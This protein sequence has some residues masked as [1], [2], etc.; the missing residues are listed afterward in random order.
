MKKGEI[1]K[2]GDKIIL[3][4]LFLSILILPDVVAVGDIAYIMKNPRMV[5]QNIVNSF[6]DLGFTID[7]IKDSNVKKIDFSK[8]KIIFLGDERIRTTA[9][10][11]DITKSKTIVMNYYYGEEFGLTDK[12]GVAN[13][14]ASSPLKVVK[15]NKVIPVYTTAKVN[16]RA[17]PYYYL[18]KNNKIQG[19]KQIASPYTGDGEDG[20][21][22]VISYANEGDVLGNGK[23]VKE[24]MCFFGIAK[25]NY[26]TS[27]AKK[28]F[29]DCIDF[30][31]V[32]CYQNTECN[33]KNDY[34]EDVCVNPGT[35]T[36]NC[37]HNPIICL[38]ESDCGEDKY[39][40]EN[41]CTANNVTKNFINYT[42]NLPGT[43][44][45]S[46]SNSTTMKL[47]E[48]C[49]FGCENGKCLIGKHDIALENLQ[50][51][52]NDSVIGDNILVKNVSY[53][54][55]IDVF[56]KGN[57]MENVSFDGKILQNS[58]VKKTFKHAEIKNLEA[59]GSKLGKYSS[60]L[61]DLT[62]G[63]Y[64]VSVKGIVS[65]DENLD[66]NVVQK[67]I[68]LIEC[69][70]K[71]DCKENQ[72]CIAPGTIQSKCENVI[73]NCA[74]NSDCGMDRV[75]ANYCLNGNV[76]HDLTF[77]NCL[78]PGTSQSYCSSQ[79]TTS[80]VQN[81]IY[82][83][84]NGA[85]NPTPNIKCNKN[86]DCNDN[87]PL[88]IDE[89]LNAG[90]IASKCRNTEIN[91]ASNNNCGITGFLGTE[92]CSVNDVFKNYQTAN[93]L[94]AGTLQSYCM[95]QVEQKLVND[96][97]YTCSDGICI[98]CN[99]DLECDDKNLGTQDKCLNPGTSRSYCENKPIQQD[100]GC[101]DTETKND[102]FE[103]GT[104]YDN[105]NGQRIEHPDVCDTTPDKKLWQTSCNASNRCEHW[106]YYCPEGWSCQEGAC[107]PKKNETIPTCEDTDTK[108]DVFKWGTCYDYYGLGKF[109]NQIVEHPDVCDDDPLIAEKKVWQTSCNASNMCDHWY[110]YCPEGWHCSGGVCV[111]K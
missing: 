31:A 44:A 47:I 37:I 27:Q 6:R 109:M 26:W 79:N 48:K 100:L 52:R 9:K 34:T 50:F 87:N 102:V 77:F 107:K 54:I 70:S 67:Q 29:K 1:F 56:N 49:N 23:I 98:R 75:G 8:Y 10:S 32:E 110:Y 73:I 5:D 103:W 105:I 76:Y 82:G 38:K 59:D 24:N 81:C 95:L 99:L 72:E 85:C 91:C 30:V 53:K 51:K 108:N 93:C 46:C 57:F 65:V 40:G 28:L 97:Q 15:D 18:P 69:L 25:T 4:L 83:C 43:S 64:N 104:C 36:S 16:G 88:T 22:D 111:E 45:S 71:T 42:C 39:I 2:K 74:K 19:F 60:V 66:N 94:N 63:Y 96:C 7:L 61:F 90:T 12:D 11:L 21:G 68:L 84:N 92:Y 89:C 58:D 13:F 62:Q 3:A 86:S 20:L 17:I 80:L 41:L 55:L 101:E 78:N 33:D 106:Y 35:R 14:A